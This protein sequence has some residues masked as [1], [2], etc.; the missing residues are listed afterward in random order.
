VRAIGCDY[1]QGYLISR[2]LAAGALGELL[3]SDPSW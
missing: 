2:P 3:R 1:A